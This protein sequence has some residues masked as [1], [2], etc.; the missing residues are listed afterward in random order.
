[1][2]KLNIIPSN[3]L[4]PFREQLTVELHAKLCND[5]KSLFGRIEKTDIVSKDG[6]W[7]C[8]SK[9]VLESKTGNKCQLP[10]NNPLSTLIQFG[11]Q[12]NAHADNMGLLRYNED[13]VT[14]EDCGIDSEI[15][16]QVREWVKQQEMELK[17]P[18]VELVKA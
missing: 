17:A 3:I 2:A 11:M 16:A 8:S 12:L 4:N 14:V 15:P 13:K 9:G 18:K 1:M 5:I 6:A 7:K 10:L